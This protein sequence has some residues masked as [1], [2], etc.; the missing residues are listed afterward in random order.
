MV[1]WSGNVEHT[2]Y[3]KRELLKFSEVAIQ[4]P[5]RKWGWGLET[6]GEFRFVDPRGETGTKMQEREKLGLNC[7]KL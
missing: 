4:R 6:Y 5:A 1:R 2:V 7:R 3:A